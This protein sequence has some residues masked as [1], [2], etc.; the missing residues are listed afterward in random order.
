MKIISQSAELL[1]ITPNAE[2]MIE[3][4]GRVCYKSQN[5]ITPDSAPKFIEMVCKRNHESVIEH[6]SASFRLITDRGISHELVRHRI[7]SFSQESTRYV[8]YNKESQGGGDIKFILPEDLTPEQIE[9]FLAKYQADQDFYNK[10]I[11]MGCTP[12]QARDGLPTGV[13]TELVMTCN[14][15]EWKHVCALR[16]SDAAHPKMRVLAKMI[17]KTLRQECPSVFGADNG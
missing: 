6:A 16:T 2:Q 4:G 12:Q 1:W 3:L 15:R 10:A 5:R 17:Q 8:N 11:A 14:F 13:K 7:A 9:L